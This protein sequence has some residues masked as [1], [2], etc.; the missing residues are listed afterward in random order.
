[1]CPGCNFL[2]QRKLPV[3]D[4]SRAKSIFQKKSS[5]LDQFSQRPANAEMKLFLVLS[6]LAGWSA[7]CPCDHGHCKYEV[8]ICDHG[9][10]GVNCDVPTCS[11]E[12]R[13]GKHQ[14]MFIKYDVF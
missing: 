2:S 14:K 12:C 9:W 3:V 10:E 4:F 1:M 11:P 8:C 6:F 7:G 13:H 5:D